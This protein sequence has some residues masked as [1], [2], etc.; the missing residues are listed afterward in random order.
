MCKRLQ[1]KVA[2]ITGGAMGIGEGHVRLF[3]EAGAKVVLGDVQEELGRKVVDDVKSKGG[4]AVFVRLDVAVESDWKKAVA[5][6]VNRYGSLTTLVNNAGVFNPQGVEEETNEGWNRV[7]AINQTGI[8][9]G[10]KTAMPEL[11]KTG[12]ASIVNIASIHGLVGSP[13]GTAYHASK[14]AVRVMSKGAAVEYGRR[15]VRVNTVYP[16]I[17]MTPILATVPDDV[18]V[19]LRDGTPMG[20][21]GDPE[22]IA[23]C[24]LYLCSDEARFVTGADFVVDGGAIAQ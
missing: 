23:Y 24:S 10:M 2:I 8:W 22:D 5:E 19:P 9:L 7:I 3:A 13:G 15:G 17:I 21:I 1:N 18:L 12:N 6:A 4:D 11:L 20:R 14:G 16:G